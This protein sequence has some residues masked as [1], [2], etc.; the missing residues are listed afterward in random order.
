MEWLGGHLDP[1]T[2][3]LNEERYADVAGYITFPALKHLVLDFSDWELKPSEGLRIRAFET[4]FRGEEGLRSLTTVGLSHGG[5]VEAFRGRLLGT[6]GVMKV[7]ERGA[8][9]GVV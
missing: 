1:W 9:G 6:G 2:E 5:T 3:F 7:L 4:R 8:L